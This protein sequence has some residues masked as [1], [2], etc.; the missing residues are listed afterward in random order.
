MVSSGVCPDLSY[1]NL[2]GIQDGGAA[3]TACREAIHQGTPPERKEEINKQLLAYCHMDTYAM[4][5]LW[6][7]W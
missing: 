7:A 4:V 2:E 5:C 6:Q 3:M 1:Q